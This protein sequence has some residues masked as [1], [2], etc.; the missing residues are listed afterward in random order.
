[1][2]ADEPTTALDVTIQAQILALL[3]QPKRTRALAMILITHD[4]DVARVADRVAVMRAGRLIEQ[5]AVA[6]VLGAPREPY[7]A[8]TAAGSTRAC[9]ARAL[10][11]AGVA[12]RPMRG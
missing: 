6:Q 7:S 10:L 3:L 4:L 11:Q 9:S 5:G 1:M 2:I 12:P 8:N